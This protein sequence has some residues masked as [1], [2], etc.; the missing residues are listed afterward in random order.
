MRMVAVFPAVTDLQAVGA[1]HPAATDQAAA[2]TEGLQMVKP[3]APVPF[4]LRCAL[5]CVDNAAPI[6]EVFTHH[7]PIVTR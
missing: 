3:P 7:N 6:A 5:W 2:T 1:L 4:H